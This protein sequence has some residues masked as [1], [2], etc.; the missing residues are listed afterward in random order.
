MTISHTLQVEEPSSWQLPS[1]P[2][3]WM[4]GSSHPARVA[5]P[6]TS[7]A[8]APGPSPG[9]SSPPVGQMGLQTETESKGAGGWG[10]SAPNP[11][12]ALQSR[13]YGRNSADGRGAGGSHDS[14]SADP[15][16]GRSHQ[17]SF[18]FFLNFLSSAPF[19]VLKNNFVFYLKT[20]NVT[21]SYK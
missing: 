18:C 5:F 6:E 2:S 9:G 12:C 17:T 8:V 4:P 13:A 7:I 21:V 3:P 14:G 20:G 19:N 10:H 11:S 15:F 1:T 16:Q